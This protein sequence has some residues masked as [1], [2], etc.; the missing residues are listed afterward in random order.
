MEIRFVA[1]SCT[2]VAGFML[3]LGITSYATHS[4]VGTNVKGAIAVT[5]AARVLAKDSTTRKEFANKGVYFENL[6]SGDL[7]YSPTWQPDPDIKSPVPLRN[8]PYW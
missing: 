4:Q 2:F 5:K 6:T 7:V 3:A 8:S 1:Y